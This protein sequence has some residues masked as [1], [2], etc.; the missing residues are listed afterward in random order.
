MPGSSPAE[1]EQFQRRSPHASPTFVGV[2]LYGLNEAWLC[3]FRADIVPFRRTSWTLW[4]S[5]SDVAVRQRVSNR[6]ARRLGSDALPTAGRSDR[7]I[8]GLRDKAAALPA[9]VGRPDQ[10]G[11]RLR[12]AG[13]L[14]VGLESQ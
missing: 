1:W 3:D 2:S 9:V 4:E 7:V 12:L 8:F 13:R 10:D 6:Y 11:A 14:H 5:G